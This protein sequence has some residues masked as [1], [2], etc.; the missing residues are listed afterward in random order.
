MLAT[1][2]VV[3][4]VH[5]DSVGNV[6]VAGYV[7]SGLSG[8]RKYSPG[9]SILLDVTTGF[10][11]DDVVTGSDGTIFATDYFGGDIY[12]YSAAGASLGLFAALPLQRAAFI[13]IDSVGNLYTTGWR[14]GVVRK[15]SP[16]GVDLGNFI[17]GLPVGVST[18]VM[19]VA[20]DPAENVYVSL[21]TDNTVR[22]YGPD[23]DSL[24]IFASTG[25]S[26]PM[27]MDFDADGNLYVAN[28][29]N[30]TIRKFSPTGADLGNFAATGLADPS[31][32]AISPIPEPPVIAGL[33]MVMAACVPWVRRCRSEAASR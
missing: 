21:S 9:G 28:R 22:K 3:S 20:L 11:T 23:G 30:D 13:E 1:A 18:G 5:V 8:F 26:D 24:G 2:P 31:D 16:S 32:I 10:R 15:V 29:G 27:G 14:D 6:Y 12:R 19:G 17:S 25:L 7:E 4:G 33:V